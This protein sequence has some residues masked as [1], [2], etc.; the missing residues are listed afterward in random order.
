MNIPVYTYIYLYAY[1]IGTA[2]NLTSYEFPSEHLEPL[3]Q[4][5]FHNL[6]ELSAALHPKALKPKPCSFVGNPLVSPT[7]VVLGSLHCKL[8]L[9][10]SETKGVP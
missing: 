5:M 1:I 2:S 7:E 4:N 3:S 6:F 8:H 10:L 9:G